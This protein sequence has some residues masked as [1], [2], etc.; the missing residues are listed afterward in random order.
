MY[1]EYEEMLTRLVSALEPL[2]D[3]SPHSFMEVLKQQSLWDKAVSAFSSK[4]NITEFG[5]LMSV[6]KIIS[7]GFNKYFVC[8]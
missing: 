7:F 3:I 4:T 5:K 8:V 6:G 2:M 1:P